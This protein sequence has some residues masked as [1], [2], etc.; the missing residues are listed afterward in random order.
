M[1][2]LEIDDNESEHKRLWLRPGKKYLFGRVKDGQEPTPFAINHKS[3]S[4]KHLIIEISP[5]KN[6]E[7]SN[8]YSKSLLTIED[9][10]SK[11]GTKLDGVQIRGQSRVLDQNVHELALGN[12]ERSLRIRW[13]PMTFTFS[14]SSRDVKHKDAL[15]P[16]KAK[17]EQLD[18]KVIMPYII[19]QTTHVV[20]AKRN[21]AKGLQALINA[22]FIVTESF[23][24]AVVEASTSSALDTDEAASTSP[25]EEDFDK[26]WPDAL[27]HL[28][29]QG[30]EPRQRPASYFAPNVERANVF[31]HYVFV[32]CDQTQFD[33]LQAP[34]TNGAGKAL[35]F[36]LKLGET[37][38]EEIVRF[39]KDTAG[40]KGTG[41]FEDGSTGKGV[42]LVRFRGK[43]G[44][45]D[46]CLALGNKVA[47]ILGQRLIEQSEFLD[48]IQINDASGL[49]EPLAEEDE[50]ESSVAPVQASDPK[51]GDPGSASHPSIVDSNA[52]PSGSMSF[53]PKSPARRTRARRA[54]TSRFKGFDDGFDSNS[55]PAKSQLQESVQDEQVAQESLAAPED[56]QG[57][58]RGKRKISP[59]EIDDEAV[60]N[61]I[62]PAATSMKRRRIE[63]ASTEQPKNEVKESQDTDECKQSQEIRKGRAVKP[64]REKKIPLAAKER[65]NF[66]E[67]EAEREE[68]ADVGNSE[69]SDLKNLALVESMPV[70]QLPAQSRGEDARKERWDDKWNGRKNFKGFRRRDGHEG[71]ARKGMAV[72][73]G[74]EEVTKKMDFGTGAQYVSHGSSRESEKLRMGATRMPADAESQP[75][76][77][78]RSRLG[79]VEAAQVVIE[80]TST[81]TQRATRRGIR[82]GPSTSAKIRTDPPAKTLG[83]RV[84]SSTISKPTLSKRQRTLERDGNS[85]V[86]DDDDGDELKFRFKSKR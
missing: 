50:E 5:V 84:A 75:F 11:I 42:V 41:R 24:E 47:R 22:K 67:E 36:D 48:A 43:K 62:L 82:A 31:E 35:I 58:G 69:I 59:D 28:P 26:N 33:N 85:D 21:T 44:H 10:N 80:P 13:V 9:V 54:V 17:L 14:F 60:M 64:K 39:I 25:L 51:P 34:I 1:W 78:A 74:F 8:V 27:Q 76:S 20:A 61:E 53:E 55:I 19:D 29:A 70:R 86:D 16:F 30:K 73:V 71:R 12:Y 52:P 6:G 18:I 15:A 23:I 68:E 56:S 40:E 77:T 4:R 45:E 63:E 83:K 57:K 79:D 7:A 81:D 37:T 49:R 38:A 2:M 46:W 65:I 66:Q 3:I 32:F 72:I